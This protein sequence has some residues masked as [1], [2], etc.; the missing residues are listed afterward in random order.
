MADSDRIQMSYIEESEFGVEEADSPLQVL[1]LTGE[2]LKQDTTTELSKEIRS[3]RQVSDVKRT[4]IGASG[5][6]NTELSFEAYDDLL[7][8]ALFSAG[9]SAEVADIDADIT[10][11]AAATDNSFNDSAS[12]L[13]NYVANQWIYVTG[14]ATAAN[15]GFFKIVSV[16]AGKIVVSGGTL[17][18][19]SAGVTVV[20]K[21]QMGPQIVNGTTRTSFNIEKQYT[22]VVNTF[23]LY[24]GMVIN[25]MQLSVSAGQIITGGFGFLG[26]QEESIAAS[27]GSEYTAA[28]TNSVMSAVDDVMAILEA[29]TAYD[30][31]SFSLSLANNLR[32]K[33][34]IGT[35]GAIDIKPGKVSISGTLQAYF[36]SS[37][38]MDKYLDHTASS[39]AIPFQD[40]AGNGYV[41]EL[42]YI[43]FS[44]GQRVA[45]GMNTDI[46]ADLAFE[47][48]MH[49]TELITIRIAKFAAA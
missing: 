29:Q 41:I 36:E 38:A 33:D 49:P 7:A 34:I 1:R 4:S 11:S 21:I 14:F 30:A 42:P 24:L 6:I 15:N 32:Q 23:A 18:D 20:V 2:S 22:D 27:L 48:S 16:V 26:K 28:P 12:G 17:V 10:I 5:D 40:S 46:I 45:G 35:L 19:E 25:S 44:S 3:D 8:A 39:I 43:K 31:N 37:T 13:G 9:W 47:A